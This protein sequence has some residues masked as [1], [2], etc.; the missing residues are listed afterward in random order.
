MTAAPLIHLENV[1]KVYEMGEIAVRALDGISLEIEQGE[2]VA[3]MGASGSGKSTLMNVMGCLDRPTGGHYWLAGEDVSQLSDNELARIRNSRI[4]FVFQ[5]FNLLPRTSAVENVELP[6]IYSGA[7]SRRQ[8]AREALERVKLGGRIRHKP[9]ELSGGEQQRVAIARAIVT[10]PDIIMADEPT[11]NLDSKVSIEIIE[12][13]WEFN[14]AGK[15][16]VIVTHE[17]DIALFARRV[18]RMVDGRIVSD[19]KQTPRLGK[20]PA[21]AN[22]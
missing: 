18:L 19:T 20:Q 15:T 1:V 10:D 12:I 11:G 17:E 2:M 16:I 8:R 7:R 5:M 4:G 22:A 6:L 21:T 3:I 13:F 9:S 14:L